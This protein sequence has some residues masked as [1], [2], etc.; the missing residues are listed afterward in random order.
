MPGG[1]D[2][3][4]MRALRFNSEATRQIFKST[5]HDEAMRTVQAI[6]SALIEDNQ[7]AE[8]AVASAHGELIALLCSMRLSP[9]IDGKVRSW[10]IEKSA[11]ENIVYTCPLPYINDLLNKT[12][13]PEFSDSKEDQVSRDVLDKLLKIPYFT[14]AYAE[15]GYSAAELNA[16]P[17]ILATARQFA[18]VTEKMIAFV[19]EALVSCEGLKN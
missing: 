4:L 7:A 1:L 2:S 13:Y 19:A 11:G 16:H 6:Q 12:P 14:K 10:H 5:G 15:D 17:A 8:I 9:A 18:G 3:N